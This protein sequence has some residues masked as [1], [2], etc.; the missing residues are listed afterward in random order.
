VK[1]KPLCTD[2]LVLDK[3]EEIDKLLTLRNAE[4]FPS[5]PINSGIQSMTTDIENKG[6]EISKA[7]KLNDEQDLF[8]DLITDLSHTPFSGVE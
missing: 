7:F 1:R 4:E 6:E 5:Q 8:P 2:L 3:F